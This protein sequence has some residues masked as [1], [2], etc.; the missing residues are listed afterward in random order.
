[1][2]FGPAITPQPNNGIFVGGNPRL[3]PEK[4]DSYSAGVVWS[5]TFVPGLLVTADAYQLFTTDVIVDPDS[6]TRVILA[7]AIVDPDGC[8]LGTIPGGGP[9]L[10]LTRWDF[11]LHR[12]G[13]QQCG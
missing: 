1:V 3:T 13:L 5:P 2:V 10:G 12:F 4:T 7:N 8:G 6:F 9:G 11:G